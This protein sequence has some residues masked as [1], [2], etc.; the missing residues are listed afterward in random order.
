VHAAS[1]ASVR[2]VFDLLFLDNVDNLVG[3]PEVFDLQRVSAWRRHM[4]A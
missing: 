2:L 1:T 3:N 4:K